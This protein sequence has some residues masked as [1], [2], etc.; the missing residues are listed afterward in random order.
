MPNVAIDESL[1]WQDIFDSVDIETIPVKYL[2]SVSISFIDGRNWEISTPQTVQEFD[3]IEEIISE[4]VR[5]HKDSVRS[6]KF[7]I[8]TYQ[9][10]LDAEE[11][12]AKLA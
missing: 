7:N 2:Q 9:V 12:N 3:Q 1:H 4:F 8:N 10:K 5:N 6:V 11:T